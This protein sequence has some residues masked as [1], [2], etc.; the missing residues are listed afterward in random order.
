MKFFSVFLTQTVNPIDLQM[1]HCQLL[2]ESN[3]SLLFCLSF[4][5]MFQS[6][7]K[8]LE[9]ISFINLQFEI[10]SLSLFFSFYHLSMFLS[11]FIIFICLSLCFFS[12]SHFLSLSLS[13][14]LSLFVTLLSHSLTFAHNAVTQVGK[15]HMYAYYFCHVC[16]K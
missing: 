1:K 16:L 13:F 7:K 12:F 14:S 11:H 3:P 2:N 4:E 6:L 8:E 5:R 10:V 9:S 15:H